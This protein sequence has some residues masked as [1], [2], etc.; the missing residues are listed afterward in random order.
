M[1]RRILGMVLAAAMVGTM[2]S[3]CI[4]SESSK[5]AT[6]EKTSTSGK[7]SKET[8][9]KNDGPKKFAVFLPTMTNP[10]WVSEIGELEAQVEANGDTLAIYDAQ[11][12]QSK[13]ISQVED[14]ISAGYDLFFISPHDTEGVRPALEAANKA[15]IPVIAMDTSVADID[16]V[17]CQVTADNAGAGRLAGEA[18]AEEIEDGA[19][20][21]ILAQKVNVDCRD[22]ADNFLEAL[23]EKKPN[24]EVVFEQEVNGTTDMALTTMDNMIQ[25]FPDVDAIFTINDPSALGVVASLESAGK[26]DNILIASVDGSK[27]AVDAVREDKV[28]GTAAQFPVEVAKTCL[29]YAYKLLNNEELSDK[30][31]RVP[32]EWINKANCDE[33]KGF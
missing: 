16:L 15:G 7:E 5:G 32:S 2:L 22:R 27:D 11:R 20:I 31:V 3:G 17:Q 33:L 29:E 8:E 26:L 9:A 18:M 10:Y 21:G 14:A 23:K 30:E 12:D 19:K 24:V 1:K 13:Q 28:L 25:S 6:A 4:K